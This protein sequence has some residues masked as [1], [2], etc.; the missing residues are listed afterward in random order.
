MA[1]FEGRLNETTWPQ[2]DKTK[3][4]FDEID[5]PVQVNGKMRGKI[6][7]SKTASKEEALELA[8]EDNNVKTYIENKELRKVIYVPGKILNI[9]V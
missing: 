9:V 2:Y 5:L 8:N 4:S 7:I 3:L 6:K 1:G